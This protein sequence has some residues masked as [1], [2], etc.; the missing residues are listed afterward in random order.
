MKNAE[1][2]TVN[3]NDYEVYQHIDNYFS[4]CK[5]NTHGGEVVYGGDAA[6]QDD[7]NEAYM[8]EVFEEWDGT[9]YYEGDKYGYMIRRA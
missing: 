3:K 1:T 2:K 6:N 9:L 8:T 7:Y 5:K 4:I